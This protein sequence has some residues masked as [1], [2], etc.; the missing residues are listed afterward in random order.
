[1]TNRMVGFVLPYTEEGLPITDSFLAVSFNQIQQS[2]ASTQVVNYAYVY[3]VAPLS[4]H[5]PT[6]CLAC[7]GTDKRY[8]YNLVVQR[9]NYIILQKIG[10][11]GLQSR[12][13]MEYLMFRMLCTWLLR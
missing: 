13:L 7:V 1:M 9:W 2:F 5:T 4:E 8:T 3:I 11:H 6:F 10:L 12:L